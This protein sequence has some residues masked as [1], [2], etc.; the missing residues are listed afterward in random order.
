MKTFKSIIPVATIVIMVA[1][2]TS[3]QKEEFFGSDVSMDETNTLKNGQVI[4]CE[5]NCINPLNPSYFEKTFSKTVTWGSPR[6]PKTNL[7]EIICFNT[8]THFVLKVK[9]TEGW[10]DLVINGISSWANEPVAPCTWGDYQV[11]LPPDW[12]ACD[13]Y[14]FTL[15]VAGNGPPALFTI[16]Y[17]LIGECKKGTFIDNRDGRTYKWV[18]IGGQVWMAENLNYGILIDGSLDQL[19]NNIIEKYSLLNSAERCIIYGGLYQWNEMM[20]YSSIEK[21]QG[22][23]PDGWHIPNFTDWQTL[24]DKIN[25]DGNKDLNGHV[26]KSTSGWPIYNGID[27]NGTDLYGFSA[28]PAGDRGTDGLVIHGGCAR[29]WGSTQY[30]QIYIEW[31]SKRLSWYNLFS[32]NPDAGKGGLSIRCIKDLN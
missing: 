22:I 16:E 15:Q 30:W 1:M 9:S 4:N 8:L 17:K 27:G 19:D 28:L 20:N 3:C 6:K 13:D 21:S 2:L 24:L 26:L 10:S 5:T 29:F 14:N 7:V 31:H 25:S 32:L 12:A 18:Q 23:C 11:E